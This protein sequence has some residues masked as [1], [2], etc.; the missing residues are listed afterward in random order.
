MCPTGWFIPTAEGP[1]YLDRVMGEVHV[2]GDLK[3]DGRVTTT[4]ERRAETERQ[5]AEFERMTRAGN[6]D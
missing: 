2:S 6:D 5:T 4:E 3:I 1:D